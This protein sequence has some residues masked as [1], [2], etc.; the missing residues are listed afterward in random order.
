M[1]DRRDAGQV[2]YRT[3]GMQD[4]WDVGQVGCRTCGMQDRRDAGRRTGVMEEGGIGKENRRN[5]TS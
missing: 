2:G 5:P 1:R 3:G 4:R